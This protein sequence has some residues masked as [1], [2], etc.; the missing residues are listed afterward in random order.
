MG[1]RQKQVLLEIWCDEK[2]RDKFK[3]L[4]VKGKFRN[5]ESF[6]EWLLTKAEAEWIAER[7]Y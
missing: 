6:L 7:I 2:T 1:K 5:Y 3:L 4:C